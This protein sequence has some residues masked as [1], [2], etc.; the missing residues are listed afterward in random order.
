MDYLASSFL[1][2]TLDKDWRLRA[3]E[4][5][6]EE[7]TERQI[8]YAAN[9]ALVAVNILAIVMVFIVAIYLYILCTSKQTQKSF[10]R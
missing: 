8:E 1:G 5:D 6:A 7:F 4:W 2:V 10:F 9:D 3:G